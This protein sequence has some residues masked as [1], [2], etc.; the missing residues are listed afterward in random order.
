MKWNEVDD[1]HKDLRPGYRCQ[2]MIKPEV[3][4][5][6]TAHDHRRF[7]RGAKLLAEMHFALGAEKVLLPFS[8][9]PVA[10]NADELRAIDESSV[11]RRALELFTVHLMGTARMGG[12]ADSSV[13]DASGE[14]WDL[15]GCYV[16]D[17]SL[18]PTA[19]GVNPQ[20]TIMA[21]ATRV[22]WRLELARKAA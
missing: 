5:D 20:I 16:A 22:A 8:S 15:P 7:L 17:A 6:V 3:R 12:S 11:P 1:D 2:T 19:I 13:V 21:L 14:V 4:Y 10:H 9:F 18:F